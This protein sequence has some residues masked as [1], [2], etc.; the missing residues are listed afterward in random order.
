M[1]DSV[2]VADIPHV[3]TMIAG[4]V[5]GIYANVP[6]IRQRF[7]HATIVTVTVKGTPGANVIDCEPGDASPAQAAAWAKR[8]VA[9]GRKPTIYCMASQW[10]QVKLAV[11][12]AG[13]TGKVSYWIADYDGQP[14][15][16]SGA[17]AKQYLGSPG[18]SPGH[19]DVSVVA[20]HWPGVDPDPKPLSARQQRL[21]R[22]QRLI[23]R[24][25]RLL[26]YRKGNK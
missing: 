23:V 26:N 13:V 4:Y 15:V 9:A 21:A 19:Y 1:Y 25:I 14:A 11:A 24:A 17:V 3:A 22:A 12:S 10:V 20:A 2:T 7:P 16:P 18:N 6:A 5:D 8:E